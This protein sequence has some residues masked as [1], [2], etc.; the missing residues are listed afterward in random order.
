M[1]VGADVP[2]RPGR[3]PRGRRDA[4]RRGEPGSPLARLRPAR[5]RLERD[6]RPDNGDDRAARQL[7]VAARRARRR[8]RSAPSR[9]T[10]ATP[11][12]PAQFYVGHYEARV[13]ADRARSTRFVPDPRGLRLR[14]PARPGTGTSAST[15][16]DAAA[17]RVAD[18][19]RPHADATGRR[20]PRAR[21]RPAT[22]RTTS[23]LI[24]DTESTNW[25]STGA[26]GAGHA[27]SS[28]PSPAAAESRS[29]R[30]SRAARAGRQSRY[31][32]LRAVRALRVRRG[33]ESGE[34]DLRRRDRRRAGRRSSAPTN[35]AFPGVNP[36]PVAPDLHL[37]TFERRPRW[38]T[39]VKFVVVD[40]QCTGQRRTFHGR[41]GQRPGQ[42]DRLPRHVVRRPGPGGRARAL[43]EHA[44]T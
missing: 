3:D 38:A 20:P 12:S 7:G 14:R 37:R 35:D 33:A 15:S 6:R 18:D 30:A 4:L 17:R 32:A 13:D 5:L 10:R 19:H 41:A 43:L 16:T 1:P 8:S 24:D 11:P 34:P 26:P 9:R 21:R 40:N 42:P 2:R 23:G 44:R 29:S 25:E 22:A 39:H 27:R 31:T 36:R 28:S